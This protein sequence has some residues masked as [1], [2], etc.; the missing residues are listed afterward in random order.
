MQEYAPNPQPWQPGHGGAQVPPQQGAPNP[1]PTRPMPPNET[2]TQV[3]EN[4]RNEGP[5]GPFGLGNW[6]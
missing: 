2:P 3:P 5:G 1:P 6:Q 4:E